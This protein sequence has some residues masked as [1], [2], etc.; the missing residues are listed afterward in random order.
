MCPAH[1][2]QYIG[3][4][5]VGIIIGGGASFAYFSKTVGTAYQ[6]GF[7]AAKNRVLGSPMGMMLRSPDDI[8]SLSGTV[9]AV[10]GNSVT[11]H[12]QSAY[13]FDDP[14]LDDRTVLVTAETKVF[15]LSQK[16]PKA[17][18]AEMDAFMK[19]MQSGKLASQPTMP[20]EP[21]TRI[22]ATVADI[23]VG[24]T[25]SVTTV[26]NIKATKTFSAS[27]IQIQP[28]PITNTN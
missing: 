2:T 24:D 20:P 26:E 1:T 13:P 14:S 17:M 21:F 9:T 25:L 4:L 23:A 8:H 28:K 11:I 19:T 5:I 10:S 3:A 7:D 22:S 18:Q 15:K 12:T 6:T 27:E 16:D